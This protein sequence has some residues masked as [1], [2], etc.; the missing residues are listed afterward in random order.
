MF[1]SFSKKLTLNSSLF[2]TE[3]YVGDLFFGRYSV[4]SLFGEVCLIWYLIN[5]KFSEIRV[6]NLKNDQ[7]LYFT[8]ILERRKKVNEKIPCEVFVSCISWC[9][10]KQNLIW[11]CIATGP[12][13]TETALIMCLHSAQLS[14][15]CNLCL[16]YNS[17][18][19]AC[20]IQT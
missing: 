19:A 1:L 5:G 20:H 3:L 4:Q 15:C 9:S 17:V 16:L 13:P 2:Y 14:A 18:W 11:T 8:I 10:S 7:N 6:L 12:V